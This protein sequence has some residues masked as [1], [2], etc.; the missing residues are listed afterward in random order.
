MYPGTDNPTYSH[1]MDDFE[2]LRAE[3]EE[4]TSPGD[5]LNMV[6]SWFIA[7]DDQGQQF[8]VLIFMP[9][10]GQTIWWDTASYNRVEV[11]AWVESFLVPCVRAWFGL[12]AAVG[13][14]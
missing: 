1:R 12:D 9:R 5:S 4:A 3:V 7:D 11:E 13:A 14:S 6:A 8:G 2:S 10:K